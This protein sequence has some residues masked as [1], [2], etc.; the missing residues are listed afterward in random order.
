MIDT[1]TFKKAIVAQFESAGFSKK[2]Q[3]W[4][5]DGEAILIVT[6]LQKS[7]WE[8]MY[9]INVGFWLKGL[10][11]A[12]FPP[13]NHCHLYYRVERLFPEK[14][15]LLLTGGLNEDAW[16]ENLVK[17]LQFMDRELIPFLKECTDERKVR[18]LLALGRLDNGLIQKEARHYLL[19]KE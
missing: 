3:N 9:Y 18:E 4:Y 7:D 13:Y 6:N 17:L 2:G 12:V 1:K 16:K 15:E 8:D 14:R 11:E 10:G 5:L 19:S